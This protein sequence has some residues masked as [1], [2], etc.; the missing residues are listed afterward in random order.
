MA[1]IGAGGIRTPGTLRYN[2]FQ[3]RLLKPLGHRSNVSRPVGENRQYEK[4]WQ[5][6]RAEMTIIDGSSFSQ[7]Q[8]SVPEMNHE[9][10]VLPQLLEPVYVCRLVDED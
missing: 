4:A 6:S 3:D 8:T 10:Q 2:G 9:L 5:L 7:I 1:F